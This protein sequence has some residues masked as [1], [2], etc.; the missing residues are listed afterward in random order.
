[1]GND[2]NPV[3]QDVCF[4]HVVCGENNG[5]A[6]QAQTQGR[7]TSEAYWFSTTEAAGTT[8]RSAG[9]TEA[10]ESGSLRSKATLTEIRTGTF[11]WE[12]ATYQAGC[13]VACMRSYL[14]TSS[15]R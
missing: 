7:G 10:E 2:G 14:T 3:P 6:C 13:W 9:A 11:I 8:D 15:A 4:I 1:M 12:F 5:A